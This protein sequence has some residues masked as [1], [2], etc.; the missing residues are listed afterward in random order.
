MQTIAVGVF[1]VL[2]IVFAVIVFRTGSMMRS[3]LALLAAMVAIGFMFFALQAEFLG[4]LQ[5]MMM[6]PEMSIMAIFMVMYMMDP[7]GLGQMD[8]S[9]QK[10]AA[11]LVAALGAGA[12][13]ALA[14]LV[15]W[16]ALAA[17][18]PGPAAQL[19][20]LGMEVMGRS[21]FIFEAAGVTILTGM[22]AATAVAIAR[23]T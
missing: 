22:I 21:L 23:R 9:H 20:A 18:A 5:L 19:R 6:A 8:M 4:T 2:A 1:G 10:T 15:D 13:L 17:V 14:A 11:R 12:G 3:A 16:G 7:G